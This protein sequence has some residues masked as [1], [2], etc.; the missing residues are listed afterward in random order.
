MS[1]R[2]IIFA[3]VVGA[4]FLVP[5]GAQSDEVKE[6]KQERILM[7]DVDSFKTAFERLV[8]ALNSRDLETLTEGMHDGVTLFGAVAPSPIEG[9]EAARQVYQALFANTESATVALRQPQ[10]R[11]TDT[12]GIAWGYATLTFKPKDGPLETRVVRYTETFTKQDG[13]WLRVA[14]HHSLIPSG[15]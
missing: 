12:T 7:S 1:F 6:L 13:Q 5:L 9:K 15:N 14:V 3:S 10:Y 4:L 11:V 8:E 2:R